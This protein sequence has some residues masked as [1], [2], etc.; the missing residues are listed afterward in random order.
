[1]ETQQKGVGYF[2]I[3]ANLGITFSYF[4]LGLE[5]DASC[6]EEKLRNCPYFDKANGFS[7]SGA[8]PP[9]SFQLATYAGI[10]LPTVQP[11]SAFCPTSNCT[12]PVTPSL[13]VCGACSHTNY[14]TSCNSTGCTFTM[15]SGSTMTIQPGTIS[16]A[17]VMEGVAFQ[18]QFTPGSIYVANDTSR[19]YLANFDVFGQPFTTD[20]NRTWTNTSIVSSECAL[21]A[22]VQAYQVSVDSLQQQQLTIQSW[23]DTITPPV[24]ITR[25]FYQNSTFK[26]LPTNMNPTPDVQYT[27]GMYAATTIGKYLDRLLSGNVTLDLESDFPSNNYIEFNWNSSSN[28][29]SWINNL[30]VSMSNAVRTGEPAQDSR[31]NG[32]AFVLGVSVHWYWLSLPLL[33]VALSLVVLISNIL[34]TSRSQVGAWKGSSLAMLFCDIDPEVKDKAGFAMYRSGGLMD[35]VGKADMLLEAENDGK[36]KFKPA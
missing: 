8:V 27:F 9:Q 16:G 4:G 21:W 29:D 23:S 34:R 7:K 19:V 2:L 17:T 26:P 22:C 25:P 32:V 28:L 3:S 18:I 35:V 6:M 20:T 11:L 5:Q 14:T 33:M 15:P 1:M 13:A 30:A 36:W 24:N 31:Y 10:I 12:W